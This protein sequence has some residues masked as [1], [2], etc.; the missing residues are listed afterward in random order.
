[1]SVRVESPASFGV[2][3]DNDTAETDEA[4]VSRSE[5]AR[6][7]EIVPSISLSFHNGESTALVVIII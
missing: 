4:T 1:M 5:E 2:F 3:P 6:I 7:S